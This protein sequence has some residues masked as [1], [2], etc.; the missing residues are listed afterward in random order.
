[1][2]KTPSILVLGASGF[3]GGSL[4]ESSIIRRAFEVAS[5]NRDEIQAAGDGSLLDGAVK[6]IE[7]LSP[8][9]VL[10]AIAVTSF[11]SCETEPEV[12]KSINSTFPFE[13]VRQVHSKTHVIH[14]SSDAVFGAG[15]APY[16]PENPCS[17]A[18]MYGMQK[19]AADSAILGLG[20]DA[21]IIRSAFFGLRNAGKPGILN[22]F[23]ERLEKS[24]VSLGYVDYV[25]SPI[26]T[27]SLA[28]AVVEIFRRR[29]FGLL[30][31][32]SKCPMSKSEFGKTVANQFGYDPTLVVDARS[33]KGSNS[34]GGLDLTLDSV[35]SWS[36]LGIEPPEIHQELNRLQVISGRI[37]GRENQQ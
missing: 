33:P 26:S 17:P 34:F 21:T 15:Q 10:N 24:Q 19:A 5:P 16:S 35:S 23:L 6:L 37:F 20:V 12:S 9:I 28:S 29:E 8:T 31:L 30:H 1:M 3:V 32:G 22:F 4:V 2:R 13:L 25:N 7:A 14:L 27:E 36:K 11:L 18:S